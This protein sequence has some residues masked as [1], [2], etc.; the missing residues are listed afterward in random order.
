MVLRIERRS[1]SS[2]FPVATCTKVEKTVVDAKK[3]REWNN[4]QQMWIRFKMN[5]KLPLR[6]RRHVC[7][8]KSSSKENCEE[9]KMNIQ[10]SKNQ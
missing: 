3:M 2:A 7:R 6:G 9:Y 8:R 10:Q 5:D 4:Q 1:L